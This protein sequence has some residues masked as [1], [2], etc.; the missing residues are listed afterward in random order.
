MERFFY[1]PIQNT[2]YFFCM[3]CL[4][5]IPERFK[6][7]TI[8]K[9]K[10]PD[11]VLYDA[12]TPETIGF[13]EQC[14]KIN[15]DPILDSQKGRKALWLS[16]INVFEYFLTLSSKY[17]IV[18]QDDAIVPKNLQNILEKNYVFHKDFLSL[19][20]TRLGQYASCNL[21]NKYCISNIL[22]SIKE[23]PIDRG[24]DHYISDIDTGT[25]EKRPYNCHIKLSNL[26][27]ILTKVNSKTS[28]KSMRVY[29]DSGRIFINKN[30]NKNKNYYF[31]FFRK[32]I[33]FLMNL[34]S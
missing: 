15:F 12:I 25:K 9:K 18:I 6:N 16:N 7:F 8:Q 19:G 3:I 1:L 34:K 17:L 23:Y 26:S 20:G 21:Y 14:S 29:Y 33:T 22:E 13:D 27:P 5:N 4:T 10:L 31:L 11:L 24:L 2:D 28:K 30:K 32:I